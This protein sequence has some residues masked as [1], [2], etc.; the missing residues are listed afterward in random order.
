M[1][2]RSG[3]K[4][5]DIMINRLETVGSSSSAQNAAIKMRDRQVSTVLVIDDK[6]GTPIGIVT[7]RDLSRKVCVSE[8]SSKELLSGQVMSS[9]LI[10]INADSSPSEAA[11]LMLKNKVRH[12]LVV[13]TK[14]SQDKIKKESVDEKDLLKPVGIITPMDF[15]RF[16]VTNTMADNK[17]T[18]NHEDNPIEKILSHYR[19]DFNFA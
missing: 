3:T 14:P 8:K 17:D 16:E 6:D 4:I 10:T 12:L 11:D 5:S 1:Q 7:E 13:E 2:T 19:D 18:D 15:T 9:P